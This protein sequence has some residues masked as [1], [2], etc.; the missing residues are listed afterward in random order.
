MIL[1][2]W[3]IFHGS[4]PFYRWGLRKKP[5]ILY[6]LL[7]FICW[8]R[9]KKQRNIK[10]NNSCPQKSKIPQSFTVYAPC[11]IIHETLTDPLI[12]EDS[13][14]ALVEVTCESRMLDDDSDEASSASGVSA[15]TVGSGNPNYASPN[16]AK[17]R[18]KKFKGSS[19][20]SGVGLDKTYRYEHQ[21]F[22]SNTGFHTCTQNGLR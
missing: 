20:S 17:K 4:N 1:F 8:W 5:V 7:C 9:K 3:W 10:K 19:S 11:G 15:P 13:L 12:S 16:K 22:H 21:Y 18:K 14:E 6:K 2:F